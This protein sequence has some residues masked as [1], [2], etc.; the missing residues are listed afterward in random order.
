M[1]SNSDPSIRCTKMTWL[2]AKLEEETKLIFAFQATNIAWFLPFSW[3]KRTKRDRKLLYWMSQQV[4]DLW[5]SQVAN[6]KNRQ[7]I[8][9]RQTI[10]FV[11][12]IRQIK[13]FRNKFV[14]LIFYVN[15]IF[16]VEGFFVQN[17]LG[18]PVH[19]KL[20][21]III[22]HLHLVMRESM[23]INA[24]RICEGWWNLGSSR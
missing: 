6:S 17:V 2:S 24:R 23:S 5:K 8:F 11:K 18:H 4:L 20:Q 12:K 22:S 7:I 13:F 10:F 14:R 3:Q 15:K 21:C 1:P 19:L 16:K 9:F